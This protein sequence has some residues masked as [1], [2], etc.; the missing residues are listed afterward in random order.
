MLLPP[1]LVAIEYMPDLPHL[2]T[3]MKTAKNVPE[4]AHSVRHASA[5]CRGRGCCS[6]FHDTPPPRHRSDI[7]IKLHQDTL[8]RCVV[9]RYFPRNLI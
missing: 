8:A 2:S 3:A 9:G 7:T 6:S 4:A 5:D 1:A